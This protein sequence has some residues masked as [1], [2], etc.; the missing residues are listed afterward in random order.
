MGASIPPMESLPPTSVLPEG[1][2]ARRGAATAVLA[3]AV[4]VV[5]IVALNLLSPLSGLITE[6]MQVIAAA[7]FL[8]LPTWLLDRQG[9]DAEAY[10]LHTR[11]RWTQVAVVGVAAAIVF[12]LF[13][14]GYHAFQ[15][16][17]RDRA[18]HLDRE[19]TVRWPQELEDRP[20]LPTRRPLAVWDER[21]VLTITWNEA[22]RRDP[23]EVEV[24]LDRA[25]ESVLT[26]DVRDHVLYT[27]ELTGRG[28]IARWPADEST[29]LV[30]ARAP[31]GVRIAAHAASRAAI[32]VRRGGRAVPGG[33]VGL[34][35][36]EV[37]ADDE[38]PLRV[39]RGWLWLATL[40]LIQVLVV[41]LP[42]E[43]FYRGLV[44]TRLRALM[45]R[46]VMI[47]GAPFGTAIVATSAL[48]ALGHYLVE[49]DPGR[50]AVFF[51]SLLFGWM[52]ERTGSVAAG[53]VFHGLSNVLLTVLS[54][55]YAG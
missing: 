37:G 43:V 13:A 20:H 8:Y 4:T 49:L 11:R 22:T 55:M 51:P 14:L 17:V 32:S 6:N 53:A 1:L 24:A 33:D 44:Q 15:T 30:K 41:G 47:L 16:V 18:L 29:V 5:V 12:P 52:R 34:G 10:G 31:G 42:E 25:P 48:F 9:C 23:V 26:V 19:V 3:W 46:H 40:V 27:R 54:R 2:S 50:L 28:P 7:M 45:P 39:E 35:R 36:W 21:G 38:Q